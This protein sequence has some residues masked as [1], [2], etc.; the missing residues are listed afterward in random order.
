MAR[1]C[2]MICRIDDENQPDELTQLSRIDLPPLDSQSLQPATAL[3]QLETKALSTGQEVM[4]HLLVH[5]WQTL[6]QQ[7][8][9]DAQRLSPPGEPEV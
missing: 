4:R 2:V 5:Q 7:L 6:D 9:A 3:D 1:L 8:A